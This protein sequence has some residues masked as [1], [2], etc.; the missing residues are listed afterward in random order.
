[1]SY[2]FRYEVED[3]LATITLDRPDTLNALTFEI[4]AQMRDLMVEI[5]RDDQVRVVSGIRADDR[6]FDSKH[7]FAR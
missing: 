2:E 1:M 4:Y 5:R 6:G 7:A 3:G